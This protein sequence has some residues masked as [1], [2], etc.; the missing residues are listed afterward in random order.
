MIPV[1]EPVLGQEE[2]EYVTDC[3]PSGWISSSGE[4]LSRFEQTWAAW[5][6]MEYGIAVSSGTAALHLAVAELDLQPGDEV[7]L[8]TFTIISCALA[9]VKCGGIPILVDSKPDTW[10]L[11]VDQVASQ[12]GPRTRAIMAVHIYGHPAD[13]DSLRELASRFGLALIEDSAEAHGA[14]Y[15]SGHGTNSAMWR[16]CGGLGDISTFSFY[17]NKLVTTGEGGMVLTSNARSAQRLREL[18][19]LCFGREHRFE[20]ADIGH[21][22]RLTNMQAA[23]GLAQA[24]R[25]D[26]TVAV[27]R[28]LASTY[29]ERL[30][31]NPHLELQAEADWAQ[32]VFWVFGIVLRETAGI[33]ATELARRMFD[34]GVETRPF[35]LGMHE[36]PVFRDRGFFQEDRFPIA[37][38]LARQGLYL[39][40][41]VGLT[42][43]Q[44]DQ[45][46]QTLETAL[47]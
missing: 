22:Y 23:V 16:N 47:R 5:C 3:L 7:I 27:K 29:T 28:K 34:A 42:Q 13:M 35:F 8:P 37:E 4:Y 33:D 19:N 15:L 32:S 38:R 2:I 20:H 26:E 14:R 9:V 41:G 10:C 21:N 30:R 46:C 12:I 44:V 17:A 43:D 31:G 39:P 45:V 18:R 25:I 11:D 40:S 6:G 1:C 24:N 36:Q